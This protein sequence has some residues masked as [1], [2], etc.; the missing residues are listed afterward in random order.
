MKRLFLLSAA[1]FCCIAIFSQQT[2]KGY[3]YEDLN[4]SGKKEKKEKGIA[5]VA[6]SNGKDVV[7]TDNNGYYQLPVGDDNIIFVIKPA[8]YRTP[9]DD[10][11][12]P[13]FYCIHKPSGSPEYL[14]Y[15]GVKPT[16]KLPP[17]IDFPLYRYPESEQFTALVFGDPQPYSLTDLD[18]FKRAIINDLKGV[19]TAVFGITLGDLAGDNLDLHIPY[20][21]AVKETGIPWYNV[22]GNHDNNKDVAADS[23]SDESFEAVFGPADYAFNYGKAHF[24]VLDDIYR[25]GKTYTGGFRK[26]QLEFVGNDLKHVPKD[27]LIVLCYHIPLDHKPN[28]FREEDRHALFRLLEDFP[29]VFAMSAHTHFQAQYLY[30]KASGWMREKP[31]HEYNVGTSNGDWYS[32]KIN[33]RGLPDATMRD[34]T[35]QGYAFLNIS[36]NRYTVDYRVAGKPQ[37]CQMSIFHP[38]VVPHKKRTSAGIYVN[39]F[40]GAPTDTI[41]YR[42]D[43]KGQWETM[44]H[45][46]DYDPLYLHLLHEWD[47]GE[48][49]M[50][51]RRPSNPEKSTHLWRGA[52]NTGLP[53][54]KHT[55]EVKATDMFGCTFTRQSIY[56]IAIAE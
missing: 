12:L 26:S 55:I 33:E 28:A 5:G 36:G 46:E 25:S 27:H 32:G 38:K 16:G 40:M 21:E 45:T 24:I 43:G 6:V 11:N 53:A 54:G 23:L 10:K 39:F 22:M 1:F 14:R 35:P 19:Q 3:V 37:S 41:V 2:A 56:Q 44:I 31:F 20:A 8:G 30:G 15:A 42:I 51:G 13:V 9:L 17:S 29:N 48:A 52:I 4:K 50:P 49:L 7:L 18:Y 47:F 34:G